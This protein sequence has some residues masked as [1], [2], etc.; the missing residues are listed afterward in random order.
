MAQDKILKPRIS[1]DDFSVPGQPRGDGAT[2]SSCKP[3][4]RSTSSTNILNKDD[5]TTEAARVAKTPRSPL[6][7]HHDMFLNP[8]INARSTSCPSITDAQIDTLAPTG[9]LSPYSGLSAK[10]SML[11][12]IVQ[13]PDAS[14]LD[15]DDQ[16]TSASRDSV[17]ESYSKYV[18]MKVPSG[19]RFLNISD[20]KLNAPL[21]TIETFDDNQYEKC[22][23]WLEDLP[24]EADTPLDNLSLAGSD[25]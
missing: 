19:S 8:L 3:V 4:Y 23:K 7:K 18:G 25:T 17:S 9:G 15:D 13:A 22:R 24:S 2:N 5:E 6:L 14:S 11:S 1:V 12:L 10:T 21:A 16:D 20:I